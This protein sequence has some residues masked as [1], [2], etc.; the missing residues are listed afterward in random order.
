MNQPQVSGKVISA[1]RTQPQKISWCAIQRAWERAPRNFW[2]PREVA[3]V[4]GRAVGALRKFSAEKR[5]LQP[6]LKSRRAPGA[7]TQT[8]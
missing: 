1:A 6:F 8:V 4:L 5:L 7:E 2:K 3:A